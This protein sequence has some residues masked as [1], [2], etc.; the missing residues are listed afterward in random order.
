MESFYSPYNTSYST[1]NTV[2]SRFTWYVGKLVLST[3]AV[4]LRQTASSISI[5]LPKNL[6]HHS[7]SAMYYFDLEISVS[8]DQRM[9]LLNASRLRLLSSSVS[10]QVSP[11]IG[12]V[13]LI[14]N[15]AS[16]Y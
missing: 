9:S 11:I 6:S 13:A 1:A 2:F 10:S 16:H 14:F 15:I 5:E 3:Y 12:S 7:H 8:A 4:A